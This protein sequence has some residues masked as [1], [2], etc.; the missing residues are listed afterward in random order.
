MYRP[1]P[2]TCAGCHSDIEEYIR[3]VAG[4]IQGKPDPHAGR[5]GCADCHTTDRV[6]QSPAQYADRCGTC[7]NRHYQDI[8]YDWMQA[9]YRRQM[10][11][12]KVLADLRE[13]DAPSVSEFVSRYQIAKAVGLHNVPLARQIWRGLIR[14]PEHDTASTRKFRGE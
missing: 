3:G 6:R 4:A 7:H 2:K 11:A 14:E 5:V 12:D 13:R 1:L 8:L 10:L 9:L